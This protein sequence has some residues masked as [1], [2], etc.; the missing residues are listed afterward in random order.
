MND[1]ERIYSLLLHSKGLKI[2]A[3]SHELELDKY[4]VAEIMFSSQNISYWYQDDDSLWYA[5]EGGLRIELP[6]EQKD[7]LTAPVEKV[8]NYNI[9]KFLSGNGSESLRIYLCQIS[10]FRLYTN[11]EIVELFRRYRDGDETAYNLIAKSQQRLVVNLAYL[12]SHK[13]ALLEELIQEGNLGL[14]RAI[15]SFNGEQYYSFSNYAKSW[16]TQALSNAM[17]YLPFMVRLPL[18][19]ISSYRKVQRFKEKYEQKYG[20][21]P[22][23]TDIEIDT[24]DN[25]DK[26]SYLNNL[27]Y[28]PNE[29]TEFHED[30][31]YLP[32]DY[33]FEE[34]FDRKDYNRYYINKLL[35]FIS[36]RNRAL[37]EAYYGLG[38]FR[39]QNN[40]LEEVGDMFGL[41]RERCRQIIEK[42]RR[43][44]RDLARTTI[45]YGEVGPVTH[46]YV[47]QPV[48]IQYEFGDITKHTTV[49]SQK[50]PTETNQTKINNKGGL[51]KAIGIHEKETATTT[52]QEKISAK[53]ALRVGDKIYYDNS[54]CTVIEIVK[55]AT[56]SYLIVEHLNLKRD[57]VPYIKSRYT[58]ISSPSGYKHVK[59]RSVG[60][61]PSTKRKVVPTRNNNAHDIKVNKEV[62]LFYPSTSLKELT[63]LRIITD[64]QLKQCHKRNLRTIGDVVQIIRKYNL[65]P[66]STRFTRYTLD[67]WFAIAGLI[68]THSDTRAHVEPYSK[69]DVPLQNADGVVREAD[70][71]RSS[72]T[73]DDRAMSPIKPITSFGD[74]FIK[75]SH[76]IDNIRQSMIKGEVIVAKPV[77]LISVIDGITEGTIENNKIILNQW[78]EQ[79]YEFLMKI[80]TRNSIFRNFSPINNPFWHLTS[81]GFWHL[82]IS[83]EKRY[84]TP[85]TKWIKE[86]VRY[87][88][89]DKGLWTFLQDSTMRRRLR[90]YIVKTKLSN[91]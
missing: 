35:S 38:D 7:S 55:D 79:R 60:S 91:T 9:S 44:M 86:N 23:V 74:A 69:I 24:S 76:W 63:D 43:E 48:G 26:L 17:M 19:Q 65:T 18:S 58:R 85:T 32:G 49:R 52:T 25:L 62:R 89:L 75:Y 47:D 1:I 42:A 57:R 27:P 28:S 87:A 10:Q 68:N 20:H 56:S 3:I 31:D 80:Y 41:T 46:F 39:G 72:N 14:T 70:Q 61:K 37:V 77:L 4:Y 66:D 13:G 82:S 11:E 21:S 54:Y 30:M 36:Q 73:D 64:K 83:G 40:T 5:K 53:D 33:S 90:E 34:N 88:Y 29:I 22:A 81:D 51:E 59:Y 50:I 78:L 6:E 16:I 67:M 15:E 71:K 2:R 45:K 84:V 8:Q 12:Y